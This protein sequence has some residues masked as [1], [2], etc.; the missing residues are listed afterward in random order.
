MSFLG[1]DLN[2]VI[3]FRGKSYHLGVS[4]SDETS[5]GDLLEFND[6]HCVRGDPGYMVHPC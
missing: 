2:W 5:G 6:L 1:E 4:S 3:T